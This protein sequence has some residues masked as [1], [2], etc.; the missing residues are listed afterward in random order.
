MFAASLLRAHRWFTRAVLACLCLAV[1]APTASRLLQSARGVPVWQVVC[2][3]DGRV[4]SGDSAKALTLMQVS[5]GTGTP[6]RVPDH[7]SAA[8]SGDCPLC[9]LQHA[10]WAPAGAHALRFVP[11]ALRHSR[12]LLFWHAPAP[13]YAWL[14]PLSRGPPSLV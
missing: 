3:S 14:A 5:L 7:S 11:L 13:L 8:H 1:L 6:S 12:P 4:G 9:L 2:R 10:A